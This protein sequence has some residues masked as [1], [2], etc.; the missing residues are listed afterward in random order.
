MANGT[1]CVCAHIHRRLGFRLQSFTTVTRE[2]FFLL[3]WPLNPIPH[4]DLRHAIHITSPRHSIGFPN[5]IVFRIILLSPVFHVAEHKL[6]ILR[7]TVEH[8]FY[9]KNGSS[10]NFR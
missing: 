2:T 10:K 1:Q 9:G 7:Y 3:I 8:E 4:F 6:V 5:A